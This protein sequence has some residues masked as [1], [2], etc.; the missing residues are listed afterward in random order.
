MLW[1][2]KT[3]DDRIISLMSVIVYA[4]LGEMTMVNSLQSF[5]DFAIHVQT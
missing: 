4:R 3:F 5:K 2:K 1:L